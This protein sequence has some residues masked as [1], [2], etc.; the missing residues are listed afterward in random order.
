MP[1]PVA[2]VL[3]LAGVRFDEAR[4]HVEDS[5][6]PGTVRTDEAGNRTLRNS[7]TDFVENLQSAEGDADVDRLKQRMGQRQV[8][9]HSF[10]PLAS[11]DLGR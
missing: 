7:N 9:L 5:R 10:P 6:L 4:H 11:G 3:H 2:F 8:V 1:E